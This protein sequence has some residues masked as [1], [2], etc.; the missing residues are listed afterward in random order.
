L[1]NIPYLTPLTL[2]LVVSIIFLVK[3][4]VFKWELGLVL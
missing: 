2:G 3:K 4:R 1:F